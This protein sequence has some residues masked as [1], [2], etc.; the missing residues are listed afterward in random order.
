[1]TSGALAGR[2]IVSPRDTSR[3]SVRRTV[4]DIGANASSTAPR[5]PSIAAIVVVRPL[6]STW[7]SSPGRRT[8]LATVPA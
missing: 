1:V 2:Q 3:S 7:T 8:P 6:G 4:T 5:G